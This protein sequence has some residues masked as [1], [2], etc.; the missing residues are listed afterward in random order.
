MTRMA[1]LPPEPISVAYRHSLLQ[2][3]HHGSWTQRDRRWKLLVLLGPRLK[4]PEC[5]FW[6]LMIGQAHP[7]SRGGNRFCHLT[8]RAIRTHRHRKKCRGCVWKLYAW[9]WISL[10]NLLESLRRISESSFESFGVQLGKVMRAN[11]K[12]RNFCSPDN[13]VIF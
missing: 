4:V 1:S 12:R 9:L 10:W 7:D 3:G 2:P 6:R 13:K 8:W 11:Y 5:H